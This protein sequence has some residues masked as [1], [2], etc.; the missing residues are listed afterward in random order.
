MSFIGVKELRRVMSAMKRPDPDISKSRRQFRFGDA[1]YKSYGT[2]LMHLATPDNIPPIPVM[3]DIV[4]ADIPALLGLDVLDKE[5]LYADTVTNRLVKRIITSHPPASLRFSDQWSM[6]LT[7]FDNHVYA[8][9]EF[10]TAVLYTRPELQK[11]H[12]HFA[13]PAPTRL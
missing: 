11:L 7:R 3:M 9:M 1:F 13:H 2:V 8:P 4:P 10:P 5:N 6:P 12:R